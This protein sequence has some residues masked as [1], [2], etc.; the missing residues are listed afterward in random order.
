MSQEAVR[1]V[2]GALAE[3]EA[4]GSLEQGVLLGSKASS[5]DMSLL[6]PGLEGVGRG[7]HRSPSSFGLE[8]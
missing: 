6:Q 4:E 7:D 8:D 2:V 5:G 1:V 3:A